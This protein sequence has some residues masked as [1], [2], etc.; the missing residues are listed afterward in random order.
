MQQRQSEALA[1]GSGGPAE[2]S[3]AA[4]AAG[5]ERGAGQRRLRARLQAA[6]A[7]NRLAVVASL[8]RNDV[9]LARAA[10]AAGAAAVKV[11][12]GVRHAASGIAFGP[13]AA[14]A[15]AIGAIAAEARR[16]G[17]LVGL[18]LGP[19]EVADPAAWAQAAQ[20]GVDFLDGFAGDLPAQL[21]GQGSLEVM[22]ALGPGTDL[23][24]VRA[25]DQLPGVAAVEA[26]LVPPEGYGRRLTVADLA[27][28]RALAAATAH[29]VV[30][31]SER[32]I[33]AADLPLLAVAGVAAVMAGIVVFG[34]AT[35]AAVAHA[36]SE[37]VHA[38]GGPVVP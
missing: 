6:R 15:A 9:A 1:R 21:L 13:L 38:A 34:E 17:A 31:P 25:L 28:Y 5:G 30:V 36:V 10:L 18:V 32:R 27:A 35:A 8:P 33:V 24:L 3:H 4:G 23:G 19:G 7:Q 12:A 2:A 20:L 16:H 22:V 11:H 26:A 29:P 37:L 14:E